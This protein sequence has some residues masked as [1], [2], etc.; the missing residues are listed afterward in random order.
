MR[1]LRWLLPC[2]IASLVASAAEAPREAAPE[3]TGLAVGQK[4]PG[5][6]LRDQQ[7]RAVSLET[8][9]Q[10]GPVAVV[11]HRSADW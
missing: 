2:I 4:A 11:F 5:F 9:L 7:G 1:M 3:K 8:L 6:T 10:R